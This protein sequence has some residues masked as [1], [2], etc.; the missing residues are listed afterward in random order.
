VAKGSIFQNELSAILFIIGIVVLIAGFRDG[1]ISN[2]AAVGEYDDIVKAY[3]TY[4]LFQ[5]ISA[6]VLIVLIKFTSLPLTLILFVYICGA[7]VQ[8]LVLYKFFRR[9]WFNA[10][11]F[12]FT[13]VDRRAFRILRHGFYFSIT[14]LIPMGLLGAVSILLLLMFTQKYEIVGAYS[15]IMGYSTAGLAVSGFAWPLIT[16][17]AEA[18]GQNNSEK[19]HNYIQLITKIF[20]YITFFT[21]ALNIGL[22]RGL[23]FIFHGALYTTGTTDVWIPFILVIIAFAIAGFE[24]ILCSI[25][26]G[27]GKGR[28]AA[29]YLGSLFL[30]IVGFIVLFV[31][32]LP[33]SP[34]INV[35]LGFLT[36]A[37]VMLPFLP[38]LMKKYLNH[39]L[40]AAI[41]LRSIAALTCTILVAALLTWP[42][43]ELL[44]LNNIWMLMLI[45][46]L[47]VVIYP[48]LLIFFGAISEKDFELLEKKMNQFGLKSLAPLLAFFRK[49]M[50]HSPFRPVTD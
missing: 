23:L 30:I 20:F 4:P 32:I 39:G 6:I 27:I 3:T 50:R 14:D 43:L 12:R 25:I 46:I 31:P 26:L 15:I 49:I 11:I 16:S 1:L 22:S 9:L 17:I 29:T 7:T 21:L 42:P 45:S 5:V 24:Y 28:A 48:I 35:G 10:L 41:G 2:L 38:Y 8:A 40:P 34:Q 33:F 47:L 36:G 37:C 19:I 44:P 13:Q 18:Y